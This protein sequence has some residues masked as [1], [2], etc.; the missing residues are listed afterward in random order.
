MSNQHETR[1]GGS[2]WWALGSVFIYLIFVFDIWGAAACYLFCSRR[3]S[4]KE[5][6]RAA[7]PFE[8]WRSTRTSKRLSW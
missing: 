4:F 3:S 5:Q 2:V 8:S 1:P 7:G 6:G